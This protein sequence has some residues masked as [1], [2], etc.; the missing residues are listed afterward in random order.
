MRAFGAVDGDLNIWNNRRKNSKT[1]KLPI[2]RGLRRNSGGTMAKLFL[3]EIREAG[4]EKLVVVADIKCV[5]CL[6]AR[7]KTPPRL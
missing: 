3:A 4:V 2:R 1:D 6:P 5:P 7:V